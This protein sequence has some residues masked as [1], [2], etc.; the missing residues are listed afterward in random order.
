MVKPRDIA[1][2]AEEED[3]TWFVFNW[4]KKVQSFKF[5]MAL[6]Y[7]TVKNRGSWKHTKS[8]DPVQEEWL[9]SKVSTIRIPELHAEWQPET[10]YTKQLVSWFRPWEKTK[11]KSKGS[12]TLNT[13]Q[14]QSAWLVAS[15]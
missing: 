4:T 13:T 3:D 10:S 6:W 2:N 11:E 15:V 9:F 7:L 5:L 1:R 8:A 14:P 12:M